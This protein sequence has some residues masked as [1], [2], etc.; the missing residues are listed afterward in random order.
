MA[1]TLTEHASLAAEFQD[2]LE[3][4][5][6]NPRLRRNPNRG[7]FTRGFPGI[8]FKGARNPTVVNSTLR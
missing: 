6:E 1:A 7:F 4:A 5:K 2:N 3:R 8:F